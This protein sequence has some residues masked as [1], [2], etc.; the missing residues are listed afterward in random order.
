MHLLWREEPDISGQFQ[1]R[2]E[3][4]HPLHSDFK[5]FPERVNVSPPLGNPVVNSHTCH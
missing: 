1:G 4:L 3:A 2:P 5:E